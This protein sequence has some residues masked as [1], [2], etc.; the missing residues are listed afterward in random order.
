MSIEETVTAETAPS[1]PAGSADPEQVLAEISSI[2]SDMVQEYGLDDVEITRET[3]FQEDLE[4]ESIDLVSFGGKLREHYGSR[5]NF[6]AFFGSLDLD[7]II[8]MRVGRLVDYVV[9][10]LNL[11]ADYADKEH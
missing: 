5:V 6:A 2:L 4:L 7:E 10:C 3:S 8:E 9:A 11:P 1:A